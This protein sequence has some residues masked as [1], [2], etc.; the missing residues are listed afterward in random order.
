MRKLA[1]IQCRIRRV[2]RVV[3]SVATLALGFAAMSA[4]GI[5]AD[6]AKAYPMRPLRIVMPNTAGSGLDAV[7]RLVGRMLT[8]AWGQQVVIDN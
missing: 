4:A 7:S 3:C 1:K 6:S 8:D 5:A 2:D